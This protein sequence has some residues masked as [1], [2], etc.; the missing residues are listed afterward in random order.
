MSR[1]VDLLS[2]SGHKRFVRGVAVIDLCREGREKHTKEISRMSQRVSSFK[3]E[4]CDFQ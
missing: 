4:I 2:R 3:G 1:L